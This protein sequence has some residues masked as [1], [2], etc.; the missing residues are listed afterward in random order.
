MVTLSTTRDAARRALTEAS[1]GATDAAGLLEAVLEALQ[2]VVRFDGGYATATDPV[3]TLFSS[4]VV[5]DQLPGASCAPIMD[6]EFLVDDFNKFSDLHRSG[7]GPVTL[8]RATFDRPLRSP[9]YA[10]INRQFGFE[11]E[12]RATFSSGASCWGA[13]NLLRESSAGD[14]SDQDLAFVQQVSPLVVAG[15]RRVIRDSQRRRED[16]ESVPGVITLDQEGRVETL[17]DRAA[18]LLDE[19]SMQPV[20]GGGVSLPAEAYIVGSRARA[21]AMGVPG[22]EPVARVHSRTGG[23]ITLRGDCPRHAAGEVAST[24]VIIERSRPS[25]VLPLVVAAYGLSDREEEVLAE[26]V[27]GLSTGEI[28]DRLFISAHTVRDHVK[29]ILEK[30]DTCSRGELVSRLFD[31]HY[32]PLMRQVHL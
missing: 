17:T 16:R 31:L 6:N 24:V 23:W 11:S 12:L 28:A 5:I 7:L 2:P 3:T 19:L 32:K 21:R 4:A 15:L 27:T 22:P 9:R 1:R 13:L 30:T 26:L 29:S 18:A 14:F 10:E 20:T 25:E 8:H